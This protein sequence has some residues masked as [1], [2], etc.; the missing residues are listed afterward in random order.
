[1]KKLLIQIS[2]FLLPVFIILLSTELLIRKIP[3][4]YKYKKS[5]LDSISNSINI[6]ILGSSHAYYNVNP[7]YF[8]MPAYNAAH[9]SQTLKYDWLIAR[10]YLDHADSLKFLLIPISYFS[11]FESMEHDTEAWRQK[12]YYLYYHINEPVSFNYKFE[13]TSLPVR[14]NLKRVYDHYIKGKKGLFVNSKGFAT[15]F[16]AGKKI[17]LEQKGLEAVSRNTKRDRSFARENFKYL[18]N[19]IDEANRKNTRVILFTA[20]AYHSYR[21]NL[22]RGQQLES[23]E[24]LE[25]ILQNNPSV[26]YR[27]YLSDPGFLRFD[28]Y[29][30]DHLNHLG[31]KKFT[32][33]LNQL[34]DSLKNNYQ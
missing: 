9:S 10:K 11:F 20:P 25:R 30:A 17:D 6:L 14:V 4:D 3:N 29:D 32:L 8:D 22:D 12:N 19:I 31:A 7:D 28:F 23:D 13:L 33:K 2:I 26:V 21:N 16:V 34:V 15:D 1:M 18:Q 27:N 5:Q 24:L